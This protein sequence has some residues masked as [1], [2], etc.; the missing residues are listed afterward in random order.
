MIIEISPLR[1]LRIDAETHTPLQITADGSVLAI[2]NWNEESLRHAMAFIVGATIS[3]HLKAVCSPS[4]IPA[5]GVLYIASIL[6]STYNQ[7][8]RMFRDL[9][10]GYEEPVSEDD[11]RV[12][13][14]FINGKDTHR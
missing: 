4:R 3:E 12:L 2:F 10:P 9:V 14:E 13:K 8:E 7:S 6:G 11:E 1:S 5:L